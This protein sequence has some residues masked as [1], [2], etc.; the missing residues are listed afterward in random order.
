MPAPLRS[1]PERSALLGV[2]PAA[3]LDGSPGASEPWETPSYSLHGGDDRGL[4]GSPSSAGDSPL[5]LGRGGGGVV[6]RGRDRHL[7]R[8]VAWKT[9]PPGSPELRARL[10]TEARAL[11]SLEHP[12]IVPIYDQSIGP[13][14]QLS[15]AL[16]IIRGETLE[17][18]LRSSRAA[19]AMG[20]SMSARSRIESRL[21]LLRDLLKAV[22]A[23][24]WAHH[25]GWVHRDLKPANLM[26]G[27]FGEVQ[28]IDW[29]LARHVDESPDPR[30]EPPGAAIGTPSTMS[31]EQARGEEVTPACDVWG[32]G[33]I[34][35]EVVS[36]RPLFDGPVDAILA[37]LRDGRRPTL[38]EVCPEAPPPLA[39]IIEH[40][41]A[42]HPEDRYPDARALAV[43]LAAYL[44][45]RRVAAY[46]YG[47]AEQ[48]GRFIR[49]WRVPLGIAA[50][51]LIGVFTAGTVSY[52]RLERERE[53]VTAAHES[54]LAALA[55][56]D[57]EAMRAGVSEARHALEADY[58]PEAELA[59]AHVLA[60]AE[61]P[62]ARGVLAAFARAP[63][64]TRVGHV[65]TGACLDADLIVRDVQA[66]V[67][68]SNASNRSN[69]SNAGGTR[70]EEIALCGRKE[71]LTLWR[72]GRRA[73]TASTPHRGAALSDGGSSVVVQ[74]YDERV[75]VLDAADGR[76]MRTLTDPTYLGRIRPGPHAAVAFLDDWI[77]G[78]AVTRASQ[79]AP[80]LRGDITQ[81]A[82]GNTILQ[83]FGWSTDLW[84]GLC[85]DG[86]LIARRHP[87]GVLV[88]QRAPSE[89]VSAQRE[90][91]AL[92]VIPASTPDEVLIG[93]TRGRLDR[94]D[95]ASAKRLATY[96]DPSRRMIQ[97]IEVA[98]SGGRALVDFE[99]APL[100][101]VDVDTLSPVGTVPRG[102]R[103]VRWL[104]DEHFVTSA[105]G[106]T[107]WH[108]P[109][110]AGYRATSLRGISGLTIE[111]SEVLVA[112]G[113]GVTRLDLHTLTPSWSRDWGLGVTKQAYARGSELLVATAHY[114]L[115]DPDQ[116]WLEAP[117]RLV[118][119]MFPIRRLAPLPDDRWIRAYTG[120]VVDLWWGR[121]RSLQLLDANLHDL[122]VTGGTAVLLESQPRRFSVWP[123]GDAPLATLACDDPPALAIAVAPG[124]SAGLTVFTAHPNAIIAWDLDASAPCREAMRYDWSG[125]ELWKVAASPDGA[126]VVAGTLAGEVVVWRRDGTLVAV[127][128]LHR[129]AVTAL[130]VDPT[131]HWVLSGAWDGQVRTLDLGT[132]DRDREALAAEVLR[133]W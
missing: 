69:A 22:E 123:L 44:E 7:P 26:I 31:P 65:P 87:D 12:G 57:A 37:A 71:T 14:G 34:L 100:A 55:Q 80:A 38:A 3:G 129:E 85:G 88:E 21:G 49:R 91:A 11:A 92:A 130:A 47:P 28:V 40:A 25:E 19:E 67:N 77:F 60:I 98:P 126:W 18:L 114:T 53:R 121:G 118:T 24:A 127:A 4:A 86:T 81:R 15:V 110:G 115:G 45:G 117:D 48:I 113:N 63:R 128:P 52:F 10:A 74:R 105:E 61:S 97:R 23:V 79:L 39:A 119:M 17:A 112:H 51:I 133:S 84:A 6:T 125:S 72:D 46:H 93:S 78:L 54:T 8:D 2:D 82:C 1:A 89:F 120:R 106:L 36:G 62:E 76:R 33:A 58:R 108:S 124:G 43:D 16:R 56:R 111:G 32:L 41:L 64:A 83:A 70:R 29:G 75:D 101:L 109:A 95:V 94:V 103:V 59:A 66:P 9:S 131:S 104:D 50:A 20:P 73:W 132:L 5:S 68:D 96:E 102:E 27:A 99:G 42:F 122:V 35:F 107:T 116:T 30:F 90:F 13:D